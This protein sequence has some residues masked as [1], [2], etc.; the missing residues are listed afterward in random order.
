M[1]RIDVD[2]REFSEW[3]RDQPRDVST[4]ISARSSLRAMPFTFHSIENESK[5][6][7]DEFILHTFRNLAAVFAAGCY[8]DCIGKIAANLDFETTLT[9]IK[10]S[11]VTG[12]EDCLKTI[13][14]QSNVEA[15][16]AAI[17]SVFAGI[18]SAKKLAPTARSGSDD[19][20]NLAQDIAAINRSVLS[21]KEK[22]RK[23]MTSTALMRTPLWSQESIPFWMYVDWEGLKRKLIARAGH[24]R[25][26]TSW[27]EGRLK[28]G[29]EVEE[30]ALGRVLLHGDI[31]NEGPDSVNPAISRLG[32][33]DSI[34]NKAPSP[35]GVSWQAVDDRLEAN[36]SGD[37]RDETAATNQNTQTLHQI[38]CRK[39]SSFTNKYPD[40]EEN[41]GW[42]GFDSCLAR[43]DEVVSGPLS[44]VPTRVIELYDATVELGSYLDLHQDLLKRS[45]GNQ[46][47]LD[48]LP[49][50]HFMDLVKSTAL[51]VRA[52][53]S[54]LE[55]DEAVSGFLSRPDLFEPAIVVI[56]A[57]G[58]RFLIS[59]RDEDWILGLL[60]AG[61]KDGFPAEKAGSRG[62][63]GALNLAVSASSLLAGFMMGAVASDYSTKSPFV[64]GIGDF[65]IETEEEITKLLADGQADIRNSIVAL[66]DEQ[67]N[68]NLPNDDTKID[69]N[70]LDLNRRERDESEDGDQA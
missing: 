7:A 28:G 43:L 70:V 30:L 68:P 46:A 60:Q 61:R 29:V 37:Q 10:N 33:L 51:F 8:P 53:P 52:F 2:A 59:K 38:V 36:R 3:L 32:Q 1:N 23:G 42:D 55:A 27:Y 48:P 17:E 20:G 67:K 14:A 50:R 64:S 22:I 65:L 66:I 34:R 35:Y 11:S 9:K 62:V 58:R 40:I 24:W 57:A 39:L 18:S 49:A 47:P 16:L 13:S 4:A 21:D 15:A 5:S 19:P 6:Q 41:Y 63:N 31:W 45:V 44:E 25:V 56:E 54:A 69:E 26:W 12:A